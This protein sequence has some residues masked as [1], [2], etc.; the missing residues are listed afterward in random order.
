V[1]DTANFNLTACETGD[2]G[3]I[4]LKIELPVP[5]TGVVRVDLRVTGPILKPIVSGTVATTKPARID[6][7]NF[8]TIRPDLPSTAAS[9]VTFKDIQAIPAAGGQ[10][11]GAG[12]SWGRAESGV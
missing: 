6:R 11:T 1:L 7:V 12:T 4:P 8:S 9:A 10:I 5:V 3:K 2:S